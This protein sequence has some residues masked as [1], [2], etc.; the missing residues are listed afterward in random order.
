MVDLVLKVNAQA[1]SIEAANVRHE[2]EWRVW[3]A[4]KIPSGKMLMPGVVSHATNLVEHP[5]LAARNRWQT[6]ESPVGPLPA[7]KQEKMRSILAEAGLL[8]AK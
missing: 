1:Y 8:K 5:Q 3:Q 7:D 6:V 2:H 4:A